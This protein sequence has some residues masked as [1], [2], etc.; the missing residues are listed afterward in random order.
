VYFNGGFEAMK[1]S[2]GP[3]WEQA[4]QPVSNQPSSSSSVQP[5]LLRSPAPDNP[6]D[7]V[8]TALD[9]LY[10]GPNIFEAIRRLR[11]A[12]VKAAARS[13][14][15][16]LS[17]LDAALDKLETSIPLVEEIIWDLEEALADLET[18]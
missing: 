18:A 15:L 17:V 3:G 8:Y 6:Y 2:Y 5:D 16:L 13:D 14:D 10:G 7:L 12:R 11:L 4:S 1:I 9:Q